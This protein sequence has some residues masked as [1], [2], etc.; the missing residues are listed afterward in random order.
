MLALGS[1]AG[2]AGAAA[3]QIASEITLPPNGDNQ[4]AEVSPHK[5]GSESIRIESAS[6]RGVFMSKGKR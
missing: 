5:L 6:P 4:R 3:P 1:T 2:P